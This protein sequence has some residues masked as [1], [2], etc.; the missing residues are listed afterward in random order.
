MNEHLRRAIEALES[1]AAD[2]RSLSVR[3][4]A[5]VRQRLR[6]T[7]DEVLTHLEEDEIVE[8]TEPEDIMSR[9]ARQSQDI[10]D[11]LRR[12]EE[13]MKRRTGQQ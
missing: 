2:V 13:L 4:G 12:A 1:G 5:D 10:A 8:A 6:Q 9:L 7:V 3:S 11:D